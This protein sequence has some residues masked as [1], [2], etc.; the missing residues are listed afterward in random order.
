MP[1]IFETITHILYTNANP[2]MTE[3]NVSLDLIDRL[4]GLAGLG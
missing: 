1:K 2:L 3:N 4:D